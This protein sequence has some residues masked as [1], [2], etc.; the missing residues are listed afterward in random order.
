MRQNASADHPSND[1]LERYA[2]GKLTEPHLEQVEEHLFVCESCRTRLAEV[3]AFVS[4][5]RAALRQLREVP[6]DITHHTDDGPIRLLV[7]PTESGEWHATFTGQELQGAQRFAGVAE[8]N[9]YLLEAFR[10]IFPEHGFDERC[11]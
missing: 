3:D 11:G 5:T 6:L 7:E 9:D 4:A 2:M 8:A 10:L 1:L